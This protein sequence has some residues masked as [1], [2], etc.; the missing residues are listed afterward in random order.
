MSDNKGKKNKAQTTIFKQLIQNILLP[1]IVVML[2]LGTWN[3]INTKNYLKQSNEEINRTITEEIKS[4]L[5]LQ[6]TAL[7]IIE[8]PIVEKLEK[9]SNILINDYLN[10]TKS[11]EKLNIEKIRTQIMKKLNLTCTFDIYIIKKDGEFVN[12]I[13]GKDLNLNF[14]N[15]GTDH[16]KFFSSIFEGKKFLSGGFTI[17]ASTKQPKIF[18]YQPTKDGK[19]IVELGLSSENANKIIQEVKERI[20]KLSERQDESNILAAGLVINAD[21]SL[22]SLTNDKIEEEQIDILFDIF[23]KSKKNKEFQVKKDGKYIQ[24]SY[25][26]PEELQTDLYKYVIRIILDKTQQKDYLQSELMKSAAIFIALFFTLIIAIYLKTKDITKPII[27]LA[28]SANRITNG[29]FNE[30]AEVVGNNEVSRLALQFNDMLETIESYYNRLEEK[31]KER[32]SEIQQ[33]KE[34]IE[35]QRDFLEE[36]KDELET[37]NNKLGLAYEEINT[38]K[39]DIEA[40]IHYALRIQQAILP[41][42]SEIQSCFPDSF[43]FYSPKAIVSGDFY[44]F[45]NAKNKIICAAADCTGHG[46]PGAFM[47]LVGNSQLNNI[48]NEGIHKPAEILNLLNQGITKLLGQAKPGKTVVRDGMDIALYTIDMEKKTAEFA[49]AHNPLLLIRDEEMQIIKADRFPI[50]KYLDEDNSRFTNH[51]LE[52]KSNDRLYVF[53]DGYYDQFGGLRGRKFL[54]K[55]FKNF[56]HEI[57]RHPMEKQKQMLNKELQEWKGD[58]EQVDDIL[59]IGIKIP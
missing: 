11:V 33:Q 51:E 50:G 40:S 7:K 9:A 32:T 19:Y 21:S 29:H 18:T 24:Y 58:R 54:S 27:K 56:I 28:N 38:Q 14:F 31:V 52:L 16:G 25:F 12:S 45:K 26:Y 53:S 10:N 5:K 39:R 37:K 13:G 20:N 55:R 46:V 8:E 57:H 34:E 41:S 47:S 43:V 48:Y 22:F 3:Y 44:W 49:G 59:I 23:K 42:L 15:F 30:R 35:A 4:I 2:F 36:Q 1:V 6:N 17:E